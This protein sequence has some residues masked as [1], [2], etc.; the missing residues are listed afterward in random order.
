MSKENF[1]RK[2]FQAFY[3]S[4]K[5]LQFPTNIT[6]RE[7]AFL[8]WDYPGMI[9][10]LAFNNH[11]LLYDYIMREVPR[12][13]YYSSTRY[14]EPG[15]SKMDKKGYLSCDFIV[16]IDADHLA[17]PCS[18][19]HD[20]YFCPNCGAYGKGD[21]PAE[22][23]SCNGKKF[24]KLT[25]ICN[26]CL[27]ASKKEIIK[28]VDSFLTTDLGIPLEAVR[29][30]FSGHRGY[31]IHIEENDIIHIPSESRRELADYFAGVGF[32]EDKFNFVSTSNAVRGFTTDQL[33]WPGRIAQ[34]L[35][36][37]LDQEIF[38]I[39]DKLKENQLSTHAIKSFTENREELAKNL[40]NKIAMWNFKGI[41]YESWKKIIGLILK[42][43]GAH[44][45]VPVTIDVHR[46]IRM[47]GLLHGKTGFQVMPIEYEH[48]KDFNPLVEALSFP[49][50]RTNLYEIK[51]TSPEVP[52]IKINDE[53]FG[54]YS[55]DEVVEVPLSTAIFLL[56]KDVADI[57][58]LKR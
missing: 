51:I 13:G 2:V 22:C 12:H 45:D 31:H 11:D 28:L 24:K 21:N 6:E 7:F 30:V 15:A 26:E 47:E 9:R 23:P 19:T 18:N 50:N 14:S 55:L 5:G 20:Y 53:T 57:I 17:L 37:F 25:W 34:G 42:E 58:E 32:A 33:G 56:C 41:T 16:D 3:R 48:L 4:K 10:H 36:E 35:L 52:V 49:Q 54:P 8:M 27:G 43:V 39:A 1:M 29:I 40:R 38:I 46:L 44:I